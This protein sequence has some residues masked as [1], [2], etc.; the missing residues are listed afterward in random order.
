MVQVAEAAGPPVRGRFLHNRSRRLFP[1]AVPMTR[2]DTLTPE[3]RIE[4]RALLVLM[5][6]VSLAVAPEAA[7]KTE[8]ASYIEVSTQGDCF[9]YWQCTI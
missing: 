9:T 3:Q 1:W 2:T 6:V 5:L 4:R 8:C 7:T